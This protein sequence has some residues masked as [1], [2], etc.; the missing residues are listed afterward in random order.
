MESIQKLREIVAGLCDVDP[1][2]VESTFS[3]NEH[4]LKSS[5]RRTALAAAIRRRLGKDSAEIYN[6]STFGDLEK[7]VGS[8]GAPA[9]S[10]VQPS[11]H[12]QARVR[13]SGFPAGV[14]EGVG[15]VCGVDMEPVETMPETPDYWEHEFYRD[16]FSDDEIAYCALQENPR[17]HFAAR[18]CAKEALLKAIPGL[19]GERFCNLEVIRSSSGGVSLGRRVEQSVIKLPFA[20]SLSHTESVAIA[21]VVGLEPRGET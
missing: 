12:P 20:L 4:G 10:H 5:A 1:S 17:M 6:A 21:M 9:T 13:V 15:L 14:P 18:W 2:E 16:T 3:L 7:V 11:T 8:N 19:R